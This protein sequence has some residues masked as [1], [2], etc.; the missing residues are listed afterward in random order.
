M[1]SEI[2]IH[3]QIDS[4]LKDE[5]MELY[6]L[7]IINFPNISKVEIYIFSNEEINIDTT[8][9]LNKQLSRVIEEFGYE[10]GSFDMIVSSPGIE[11]K[12]KSLRHFELS[13]GELVKLKLFNPIDEIYTFEG[14]LLSVKGKNIIL[15]TEN[16]DIEINI[17]EI[18]NAKI[19]FKQFKE[20]VKG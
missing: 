9:R 3:H 12:L 15:K 13:I 2:E 16:D 19:E 20:K 10:K 1:V 4:Y 17:S 7:N 6:D 11:R 14:T 8:A 18:K 5:N